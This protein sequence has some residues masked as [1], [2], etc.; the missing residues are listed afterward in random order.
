LAIF[1]S[2]SAAISTRAIGRGRS[3][4]GTS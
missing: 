2:A 1:A 3:S 4:G